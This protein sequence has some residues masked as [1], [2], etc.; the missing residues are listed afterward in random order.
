MVAGESR[1]R[2]MFPQAVP[3]EV[4]QHSMGDL[5]YNTVAGTVK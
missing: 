3:A 1:I 4:K 5:V 2:E